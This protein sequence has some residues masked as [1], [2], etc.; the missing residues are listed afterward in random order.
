[1]DFEPRTDID[2]TEAREEALR[3][4]RTRQQVKPLPAQRQPSLDESG[5]FIVP[6]RI[7]DETDGT[8]RTSTS[9]HSNL[10]GEHNPNG[11]W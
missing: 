3:V 6:S 2:C 7:Q 5:V 8:V 4:L 9:R 10:Y 11:I 1:M